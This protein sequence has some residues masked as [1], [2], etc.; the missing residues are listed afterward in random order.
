MKAFRQAPSQIVMGAPS[1][2]GGSSSTA[3]SSVVSTALSSQY[4]KR[5]A[6]G[7]PVTVSQAQ[8]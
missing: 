6:P 7:P 4:N 2:G 1:G 5:K 3:N 8:I